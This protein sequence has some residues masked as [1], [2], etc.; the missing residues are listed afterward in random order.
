MDHA[1]LVDFVQATCDTLQL[2]EDLSDAPFIAWPDLAVF[3]LVAFSSPLRWA[4]DASIPSVLQ[5]R[6]DVYL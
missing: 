5:H 3:F 4:R 2:E 6:L 1:V